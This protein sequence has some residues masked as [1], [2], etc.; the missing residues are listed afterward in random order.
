M[1]V[2][3]AQALLKECLYQPQRL[4]QAMEDAGRLLGYDYFCLVAA[5]LDQPA[6]IVS[7]EQ[8]E[9]VEAYFEGGWFDVD[10]RART[11]QNHP[12]NTLYLDHQAVSAEE[13]LK[14]A[15]YNE[16]YRPRRM[17]HYAG[18]RFNFNDEEWFCSA[19]RGEERGP[20]SEAE[21]K[22]FLRVARTAMHAASLAGRLQ[23]SRASGIIEGLASSGTAA[24]IL[25]HD[26]RVS[27]ATPAAER[28][29]DADFGVRNGVLWS[30]NPKDGAQLAGLA[31]AAR[32]RDSEFLHT[33]VLVWGRARQRPVLI[34]ASRVAGVGLDAMPG[35]RVLLVLSDLASR[36]AVA[37]GELGE[38]FGLTQAEAEIA[39]L[40]ADGFEIADIASRRKVVAD[41]VRVQM[42][43]IFRKLDINRQSDLV[44]ML[45]RLKP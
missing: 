27:S 37:P 40:I 6:F 4:P 23:Q 43:S 3:A 11:E 24:V 34:R 10:F 25:N 19:S 14:S 39:S 2:A 1:S 41:T 9:G 15:V 28:L 26:G 42:K 31:L 35:G 12:L 45:A 20:F 5:N 18:I 38:L 44:R 21:G 32:R 16:L 33:R 17:A 30:G 8:R 36:D 13:R 22:Q 29:F 7:D